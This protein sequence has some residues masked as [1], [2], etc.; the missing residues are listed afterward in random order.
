MKKLLSLVLVLMLALGSM[1]SAN[2]AEITDY[3][4]Y[5][6]TA[7]EMETWNI[8]Y[9]QNAADLNYLTNAIDGLLTNDPY[10]NLVGNAAK[11]WS[12]ED[13]GQTWTFILNEGMTWTNQAGE[14]KA[15]VTAV[16]W[17]TGL[18]WI[19][20]F[21]KND[22]ANTSMP[23]T[24]IVGA[25]DYYTYTKGYGADAEAD[26]I[27]AFEA[28]C[29]KYG[30]DKTPLTA[31]EAKALKLEVFD[32]MVGCDAKDDYTL[33]Y[34]CLDK[35]AYFPTLATYNC[36][37]P[38]SAALIEE[39]G[40]DGYYAVTPETLWYSGPY[41][42][43]SFVHGNEKIFTPNP[44][45]WNA[46]NVSRFNSVII[47]AVESGD[48]AF[49]Y[50]QTGEIDAVTLSQSNLSSIYSN[51]SNEFHD[52]LVEGRRDKYS[53]SIRF[54]YN[55]NQA[56]GVTPDDNWNKAIANENFRLALLYGLD[57][58]PYLGRTN[59]INPLKCQNLAY[60]AH[61]V[62]TTSDGRDYVDLVHD[63]IG[64]HYNYEQYERF[65]P[66]LAAEYKA[67]AIEEL[68]AEGVTFPV[69]IDYYI[70]GSNQ[71]SMDTATVWKQSISDTM[72]DDFVQLNI[73]TYV[74]S[75]TQE[76]RNPR[77][78][79][80]SISGWGADFGDPIN[81]MGQETY[82]DDNAYYAVYWENTNDAT[83]PELIAT[84]E[85][86]TALVEEAAAITDDIDAR[87]AAFAKAE[88]YFINHAIAIPW[89]YNISWSLTG[90][91]DYS[92]PFAA[93]GI[94]SNRWV[95]WETKLELYT[96]DDYAAI[97]EE[98]NAK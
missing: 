97:I 74:S 4:T 3:R 61:G 58:V 79:S 6:T 73:C 90:V 93:Y 8:L 94:Q 32:I 26:E 5:I 80:I 18:E 19:L 92:K 77:K 29:E 89:S 54:N 62:S 69:M 81:F 10:G 37:Y 35:F 9:S 43:T 84:L 27:A 1:V 21:H 71:T 83:D 52:Y 95:N 66:E 50:F 22:A 51:E 15:N 17:M 63:E 70:S 57:P 88:A 98:Y 23:I 48:V 82:G 16:D 49:Q 86:F 14:V 65:Q 42:C 39:I 13:G 64:Y 85:E 45:Y 47:K 41:I 59:F 25:E 40:V 38:L 67:K 36:L 87:L 12:S 55:K 78:H 20:N 7:G 24:M 33:V 56:D 96:S 46:A 76:V 34:T 60:T 31:D 68:T 44:N 91:N 75:S 30:I 53:Y 2:A 72:G 28:V 11:E